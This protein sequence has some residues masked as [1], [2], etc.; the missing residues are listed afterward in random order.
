MHLE[1]EGDVYVNQTAHFI[2]DDLFSFFRFYSHFFRIFFIH[3]RWKIV[4]LFTSNA[5]EKNIT[6]ELFS[7]ISFLFVFDVVSFP[8]L[9]CLCI[10]R[11]GWS[12]NRQKKRYFF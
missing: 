4:N 12:S 9:F 7:E 8:S 5:Y 11:D 2:N 10:I 3:M 6:Q 1:C